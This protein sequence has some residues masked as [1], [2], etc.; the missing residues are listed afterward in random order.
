MDRE[1]SYERW[2]REEGIPIVEGYGVEDF[3]KL[4]LAPWKRTGGNGAFIQLKGME[5]FTGMYIGEIPPGKSLNPEKHLYDE[6][7]YILKG[8]GAAEVCLP[9]D[10]DKKVAFE[11]EE[12]GIFAF[13]LNCLHRMYNG[14]NEPAKFLAVTSAPI[15][16]DMLHDVNFMFNCDYSFEDRFG[17][18]NN[19]YVPTNK[20]VAPKIG[21]WVWE[22]NF[23][24]DAREALIDPAD[25]KGA[26]VRLTCLQMASSPLTTHIAEWPVGRYHKG[27]HHQGGAVILILKSQGYTLMWPKESGMRPYRGGRQEDVVKID[28]KVGSFFCP[29][30]GWFHQHFN[31]GPGPARQLA[32]RYNT[33]SGKYR[34]GIGK[35][36]NRA[37]V[38]VSTREGG[39]LIEYEDEDPQIRTDYE[40]EIK[41]AGVPS[42]MP[43]FKYRED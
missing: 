11:W 43:T 13:P 16:M 33:N 39:T 19:F 25:C 14:S 37:G 28:W 12:G 36:L 40:A 26:G 31:T 5:G 3:H 22:T 8:R 41:A 21:F 17:G 23:V 18:E 24:P 1:T 10:A 15:L 30:T 20:R 7:I 34:V 29:P 42:Q 4:E 38:S 27:H 6:M 35:A 32:F 9:K 2:I